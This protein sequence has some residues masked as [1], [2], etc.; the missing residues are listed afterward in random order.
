MDLGVAGRGYLVFGGSA[1]MGLAAARALAADGANV[2]IA[3]RRSERVATAA[4]ELAQATGS[5][6][7]SERASYLTGAAVNVDG[8]TDF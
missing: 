7:V 2:A 3:G 6:V 5:N 4:A 8:G 1:G